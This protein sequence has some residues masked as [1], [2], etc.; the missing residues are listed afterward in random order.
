MDCEEIP[1][2]RSGRADAAKF[3]TGDD[4]LITFAYWVS[5]VSF[6]FDPP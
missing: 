4:R 1:P 6:D 5:I 2:L 3:E